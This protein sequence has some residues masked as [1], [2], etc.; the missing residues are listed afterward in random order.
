[1]SPPLAQ[2]THTDSLGLTDQR[3]DGRLQQPMRAGVS[4]QAIRPGDSADAATNLVSR[5]EHDDAQ[6]EIDCPSR[7]RQSRN[8]GT[9]DCQIVEGML[10]R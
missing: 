9:D 4:R 5:F 10:H 7:G 3:V 2:E 1:M 8:S 6:A